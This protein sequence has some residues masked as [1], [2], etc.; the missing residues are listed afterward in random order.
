MVQT[1]TG[2]RDGF[3]DPAF[4]AQVRRETWAEAQVE[5]IPRN[6]MRAG[7]ERALDMTYRGFTSSS[8]ITIFYPT[9]FTFGYNL[10][11]YFFPSPPH[12]H[13]QKH[14]YPNQLMQKILSYGF[15]FRSFT[16]ARTDNVSLVPPLKKITLNIIIVQRKD[17]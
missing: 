14:I 1:E 3:P 17:V 11:V 9:A 13:T 10:T 6:I 16:E 5:Q 12:L 2:G 4:S 8:L 7:F 15:K